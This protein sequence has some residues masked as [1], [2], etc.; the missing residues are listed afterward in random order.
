M[1][2]QRAILEARQAEL[3]QEIIE[4]RTQA[5][6]SGLSVSASVATIT[7]TRAENELRSIKGKLA[8][9]DDEDRAKANVASE[10]DRRLAHETAQFWFRRFFTSLGLVHAAAFAAIMS[11]LFQAQHPEQVA[12]FAW[13]PLILFGFGVVTAGLIPFALYLQ[14]AVG[15]G[16]IPE[17][18]A[19]ERLATIANLA[20][21]LLTLI[22][23]VALILALCVSMYGVWTL[24]HPRPMAAQQITQ[25][26]SHAAPTP[27][28]R[29][30]SVPAS[31]SSAPHS[32]NAQG[33]H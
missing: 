5:R 8:A 32:S 7:I 30:S 18:Q 1:A 6:G 28:G 3:Q 33:S 29:I 10:A 20:V 19:P 17:G 26:N 23:S 12:G 11:G 16:L 24:A 15:A 2:S 31:P 22:S 21:F 9:L 4:A 14:S 25:P 13:G 27:A